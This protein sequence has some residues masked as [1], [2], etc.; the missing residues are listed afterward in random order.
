M[1]K[2]E[3]IRE[4]IDTYVD[5]GCLY[6]DRSCKHLS[7]PKVGG[8][9]PSQEDAYKCLMERLGKIGVVIKVEGELP[10]L[11]SNITQDIPGGC[12]K[13]GYQTSQQ[14]MLEAGYVAV[15]PLIEER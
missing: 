12:Y 6:P 10:R 14:D 5:D 8:Y 15:E 3:E 7:H 2:Q 11:P 9:C 13:I 4:V 1:S